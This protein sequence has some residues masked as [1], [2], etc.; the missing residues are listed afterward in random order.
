MTDTPMSTDTITAYRAS[1]ERHLAALL[2][3]IRQDLAAGLR[4]HLAEVAS[5]LRPGETLE[6]RLGSP[7]QCASSVLGYSPSLASLEEAILSP[8]APARPATEA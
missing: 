6:H 4:A 5:E 7:A 3:E 2:D 1:V 8:A